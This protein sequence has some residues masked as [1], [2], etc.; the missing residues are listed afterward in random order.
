MHDRRFKVA[1]PTHKRL[2]IATV[3]VVLVV[4]SVWKFIEYRMQPP[5]PPHKMGEPMQSR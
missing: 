5:P 1:M 2:I 3:V 4:V